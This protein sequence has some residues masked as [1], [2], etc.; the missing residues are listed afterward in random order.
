MPPASSDRSRPE[1]K[2]ILT[3]TRNPLC[4]SG[5]QLSERRVSV[6]DRKHLTPKLNLRRITLNYLKQDDRSVFF[7]PST[8]FHRAGVA[9]A[10][11]IALSFTA[12][13]SVTA[14]AQDSPRLRA[15]RS[16]VFEGRFDLSGGA[17]S[18]RLQH[19]IPTLRKAQARARSVQGRVAICFPRR[20]RW[21]RP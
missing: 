17:S 7:R 21:A 19:W 11:A 6:T 10:V 16:R 20:L 8:Y 5:E 15:P 3:F 13:A 12:L 1:S 9:F 18:T 4:T 14:L 2:T